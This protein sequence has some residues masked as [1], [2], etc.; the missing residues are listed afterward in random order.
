MTSLPLDRETAAGDA[1]VP[2]TSETRLVPF[3][4]V[5]AFGLVLTPFLVT[6]I[7]VMVDYPNHLSRMHVLATIADSP[8]LQA[9]YS[10][11]WALVP[12][13]AMDLLV[14]A[15]TPLLGLEMAGKLFVLLTLV[16][17]VAGTLVTHFALHR[18]LS[19]ASL[20]IHFVL[21]N[22]VLA[23]GFLNFLFGVGMLLLLFGLWLLTGH[24][25]PW[26]RLLLT[27]AGCLL[28][29][30]CHLIALLAF[31]CCV[32]GHTLHRQWQRDTGW[33]RRILALAVQGL[34]FI[35]PCA[36]QVSLSPSMGDSLG[37]QYHLWAKLRALLSPTLLYHQAFDVLLFLCL[38]GFFYLGFKRRW[39]VLAPTM[40]LPL[41]FLGAAI[42]LMPTWMMDNWG[43]DWRLAIPLACL[44]IAA[45]AT[46]HVPANPG[47]AMLL[48]GTALLFLRVG[49]LVGDW[50]RYNDLYAEFRQ[51][52]RTLPAGA[53]VLPAYDPKG[54]PKRVAPSN[55]RPLFFHIPTLA[56][57]ERPLFIPTLFTARGR[58]ILSV[59]PPSDAHDVTHSKPMTPAA[60][61]RALLPESR[62]EL[63]RQR[64][65]SEHYH[66]FAGW[67]QHFDY[68]VM[69]D[70]GAPR[71]LLPEILQPIERG[72]FFTIYRI[73]PGTAT[74]RHRPGS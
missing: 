7:P 73:E 21:Y 10:D 74:R 71:N 49:P 39:L 16:T 37:I 61:E 14:P 18:R 19:Y 11:D 65:S 59:R 67:P 22:Y 13:L 43:N 60:L 20:A 45:V 69:L 62:D 46:Q 52:A 72:S 4:H 5:L 1:S 33:P 51:A 66:R 35:P 9:L 53:R 64:K 12:N 30:F 36:L 44:G 54:L 26:K 8:D 41:L 32:A 58:Q 25:P 42:V 2:S 38:A 63:L 29:Y 27:T 48:V 47:R 40:R 50:Q 3:L 31:G 24:W 56:L 70:F 17:I 23:F 28:L 6:E 68:L 55:S 34:P 57:I 15:L